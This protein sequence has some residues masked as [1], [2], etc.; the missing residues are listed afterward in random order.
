MPNFREMA[1]VNVEGDR[2]MAYGPVCSIKEKL[3][4]VL[5]PVDIIEILWKNQEG[6]ISIAGIKNDGWTIL[7][8]Y[9]S[10]N[11]DFSHTIAKLEN[12]LNNSKGKVIL[13]GDFNIDFINKST[14][15][16]LS[17]IC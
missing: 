4:A 8:V 3:Y 11:C 17:K 15:K 14:K 1:R 2:S 12:C 5:G 6:S 9:I 16:I 7:S 10:P 13:A